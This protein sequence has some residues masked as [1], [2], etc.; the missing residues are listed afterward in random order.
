MVYWFYNQWQSSYEAIQR[1]LKKK[2]RFAQGLPE[3]KD[4]LSNITLA[5]NNIIVIDDLMSQATDSPVVSKLFTQGRHHNASVILLLQN[6]YPKGKY[7]TDIS[8]NATY[9]VLFRSPGDRKQIDIMAEQTFAKDRPHFMKAYSQETEQPYGYI[10]VDNHPRTTGKRQVV[11]N[12]FGDCQSYPVHL[13]DARWE[14]TKSVGTKRSEPAAKQHS[15]EVTRQGSKKRVQATVKTA[16]KRKR[17]Q[18]AVKTAKKRQR[19]QPPMKKRQRVQSAVKI[20]QPKK[21]PSR[22]L[23]SPGETD[24]EEEGSEEDYSEGEGSEPDWA[25]PGEDVSDPLEEA[26]TEET[27]DSY[28]DRLNQIAAPSDEE[29]E[30]GNSFIVR[31]RPRGGFGSRII[32]E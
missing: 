16:Q 21:R 14:H 17:V 12:V 19:G 9:K 28:Q 30:E 20:R 6:M 31:P 27:W 23:Y 5:R 25:S 3:L 8:R 15:Y 7:N 26:S 24:S 2:I 32:Y 13:P 29:R 11:A 1:A 22:I 4:D 18:S 10:I